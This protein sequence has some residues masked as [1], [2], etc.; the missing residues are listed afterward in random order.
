MSRV[1]DAYGGDESTP[2]ARWSLM[3]DVAAFQLKLFVDGLRDVLLVPLSLGAA[4]LD[5]L[6][7]GPR[8]GRHFYDLLGFGRRTEEWIDLFGAARPEAERLA[9]TGSTPGLDRLVERM[10][11]LARQEYERGGITTS[12]KDAVDRALDRLQAR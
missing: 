1:P 4:A 8:A 10:E 7:T 6:A 12:A 5:L 11:A 3:R 9:G 2:G